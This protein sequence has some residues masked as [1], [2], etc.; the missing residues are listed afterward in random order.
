[1]TEKYPRNFSK[2]IIDIKKQ[3]FMKHYAWMQIVTQ[4]SANSTLYSL[5]ASAGQITDS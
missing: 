2:N 3:I 5:T 1:M 4:M